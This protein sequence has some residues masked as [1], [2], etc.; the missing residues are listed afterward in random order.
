MKKT[1]LFSAILLSVFMNL[2]ASDLDVP[3][4]EQG[5]DS[6]WADVIL[7]NKSKV[8]IRQYGC[9]L[10][11]VS[12]ITSYF[13]D[14]KLNPDLMNTWLK[15][16]NG[17]VDGYDDFNGSYLGEVNMNWP[18]LAGFRRGYVYSRHNWAVNPADTVLI[19]YYLENDIPV[20]AE[21]LLRGA[22]HYVVLKGYDEQGFLMND[23]E[24]PGENRFDKL[25]NISDKWGSGPAR[26]IYGIRVLYPPR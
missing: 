19:R 14:E 3:Y 12:M 21:V 16:N 17:F 20:I 9:T 25:Y 5:N 1:T 24:L 26:N 8:T 11:C 6:P 4:Y 23:P 15:R 18:A 7:G 13:E 22:P 2:S 10:T